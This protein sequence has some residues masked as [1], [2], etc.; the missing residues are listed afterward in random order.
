MAKKALGKGLDALISVESEIESSSIAELELEKI[1]VNKSQPRKSFDEKKI[2]ELADSIKENGVIQ[3]IV[4]RKAGERYQIV[5][6]ERRYRAAKKAGLKK[7]PVVIKD[8]NDE[9][10][11]EIALIENIQ[12]EDLNPIEEAS[13]YKTII[14]RESITQEELAKRIGKSRSYIANMMRLLEL[15]DKI[16][17]YVSRGTISVGHAKAILSL[18][19]KEEMEKYADEI[20][21]RGLSVREIEKIVKNSGNI[22]P[23]ENVPRETPSLENPFVKQVEESLINK[24][25]TKVKVKYRAGK[26]AILIEFF[27][28]EELERLI[29]ILI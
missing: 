15:P 28:D 18:N 10:T 2:N 23:G 26:G 7:I 9:K 25:G 1:D 17:E 6:G 4:V 11:I 14:E 29:D 3:P 8:I 5:V 24:L 19:K 20:I 13:A 12:R 27:S 16:K 22:E 21:N